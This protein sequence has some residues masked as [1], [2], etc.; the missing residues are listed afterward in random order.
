MHDTYRHTNM[1]STASRDRYMGN[2]EQ[3]V[4]LSARGLSVPMPAPVLLGVGVLPTSTN[5][6]SDSADTSSSS[7][8]FQRTGSGTGSALDSTGT[9]SNPSRKDSAAIKEGYTGVMQ[10]E[11]IIANALLLQKSHPYRPT[12]RLVLSTAR[13]G[14]NRKTSFILSA[15]SSGAEALAQAWLT[16][17][18]HATSTGS[19]ANPLPLNRLKWQ[20]RHQLDDEELDSTK[21]V[22]IDLEKTLKELGISDGS[23]LVLEEQSSERE[24]SKSDCETTARPLLARKW[25]ISRWMLFSTKTRD[26]QSRWGS[27]DGCCKRTRTGLAW[28]FQRKDADLLLGLDV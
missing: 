5:C 2:L 12:I 18:Q 8:V 4:S 15:D 9:C 20:K 23:H 10:K 13:S 6:A 7:L 27:R 22:A 19:L 28:W 25:R 3:P 11:T 24:L 1:P 21:L 16:I 17:T 26:G 14:V